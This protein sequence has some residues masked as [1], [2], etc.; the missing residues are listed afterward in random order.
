[1]GEAVLEAVELL[2]REVSG[3]VVSV[4]V[5]AAGAGAGAGQPVGGWS[6]QQ[7]VDAFGEFGL[8][9]GGRS[10]VDPALLIADEVALVDQLVD[11]GF[12]QDVQY[13]GPRA[14]RVVRG[15]SQQLGDPVGDQ[16]ADAEY[17][18]EP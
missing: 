17:A 4:S 7:L 18:G 8:E 15:D 11:L 5:A 16:E 6:R 3:L 14:L 12:G 1:M 13:G 2:G 10:P 9:L